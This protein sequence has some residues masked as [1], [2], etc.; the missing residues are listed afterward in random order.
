LETNDKGKS[1]KKICKMKYKKMSS[2][3]FIRNRSKLADLLL[4]DSGVIVCSSDEMPRNGDQFFP[5]RQS[6]DLFYLT[7]IDQQ[8]TILV[9]NP[10]H[11]DE[12]LRETLFIFKASPEQEIWNGK[13][14]TE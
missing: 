1:A 8:K 6:S 11:K 7:G 9:M 12:K 2:A 4:P 13:K 14:F 5:Y 10:R 3:L